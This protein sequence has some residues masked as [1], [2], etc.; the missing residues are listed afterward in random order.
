[1]ADVP[2]LLTFVAVARAGSVGRAA[3]RRARTQ[4]RLSARLLALEGAWGTKLFRRHARG[5][6]LTP[7]GA[8]LLP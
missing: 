4:P 2:A 8:R 3:E 7:E 6:A 5:M 1:M